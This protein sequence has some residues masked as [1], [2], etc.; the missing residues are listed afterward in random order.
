MT[1][2]V[3]FEGMILLGDFFGL[4]ARRLFTGKINL[5]YLLYGDRVDH[6]GSSKFF[7]P[8]RLKC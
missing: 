6:S 3:Y 4:I 8:G 7:S 5:D 2:L 1:W